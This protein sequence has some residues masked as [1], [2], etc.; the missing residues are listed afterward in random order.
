VILTP[1]SYP[2]T[3]H[4]LLWP[5]KRFV[6]V[7]GSD[8]LAPSAQFAIDN[9]SPFIDV[10]ALAIVKRDGFRVVGRYPRPRGGV[11]ATLLERP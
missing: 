11:V 9:G 6:F 1:S 4:Y 7:I 8:P 3:A 5:D 10:Y 2:D